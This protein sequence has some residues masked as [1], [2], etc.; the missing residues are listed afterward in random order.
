M[1]FHDKSWL[2]LR[3]LNDE[4]D[5]VGRKH[6]W[7]KCDWWM[8]DWNVNDEWMIEMLMMNECECMTYAW[9]IE[10]WL[11]VNEWNVIEWMRMNEMWMN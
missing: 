7:L 2:N 3:E 8:N 9:M 5:S 11:N 1:K 6:E 4:A 10:M